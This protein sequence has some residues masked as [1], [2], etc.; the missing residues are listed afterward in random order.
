MRLARNSRDCGWHRMAKCVYK[1]KCGPNNVAI[2]CV[3]FKP[4]VTIYGR[5]VDGR[6]VTERCATNAK[7][8][9]NNLLKRKSRWWKWEYRL[10]TRTARKYIRYFKS[11]KKFVVR[12]YC[13]EVAI[14]RCLVFL[15]LTRRDNE[16][17]YNWEGMRLYFTRMQHFFF[18]HKTSG[19][20]YFIYNK[21][22][23]RQN[24]NWCASRNYSSLKYARGTLVIGMHNNPSMKIL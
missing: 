18:L 5:S 4:C 3:H 14:W 22:S 15:L 21:T 2:S 11:G 16:R 20:E 10:H 12:S 9:G 24:A 8:S 1:V 23:G 13:E 17:F 7:C 19:C 6:R